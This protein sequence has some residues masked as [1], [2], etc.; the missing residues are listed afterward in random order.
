MSIFIATLIVTG[1]S[2]LPQGVFRSS[3]LGCANNSEG[4]PASSPIDN[5]M[6]SSSKSKN[7][8]Y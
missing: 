3:D 7:T 4:S 1:S 6:T 2:P 8:F 5:S